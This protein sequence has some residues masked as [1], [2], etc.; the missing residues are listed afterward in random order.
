VLG[1]PEYL[2]GCLLPLGRKDVI[3]VIVDLKQLDASQYNRYTASDIMYAQLCLGTD[4]RT[5]AFGHHVVGSV[6]K[7]RR[8]ASWNM[9]TFG[10]AV[11]FTSLFFE[12]DP[13]AW[14]AGFF[15]GI[16]FT[17]VASFAG[18]PA[19]SLGGTVGGMPAL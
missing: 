14:V 8:G 4:A 1:C 2:L 16:V 19:F 17:L 15:P 9:Q 6:A 13:V 3:Q 12:V 10:A 5:S 18:P 7:P 11:C